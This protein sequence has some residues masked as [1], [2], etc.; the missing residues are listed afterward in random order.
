MRSTET[1]KGSVSVFLALILCVFLTLIFA[2]LESARFH[3]AKAVLE[4]A[5]EGAM[6]SV[7]SGYQRELYERYGL[8]FLDGGFGTGLSNPEMLEQEYSLWFEKNCG[9]SFVS[10]QLQTVRLQRTVTAADYSGEVFRDSALRIERL[11]WEADSE[12]NA[13]FSALSSQTER[14]LTVLQAGEAAASVQADPGFSLSSDAS[15]TEAY[16]ILSA[17][18]TISNRPLLQQALPAGT[19]LSGSILSEEGLPSREMRDAR[20]LPEEAH[21]SGTEGL[22]EGEEK[23]LYLS[24]LLD[25]FPCF[26]GE[27]DTFG[28][29]CEAEYLAFGG[30]SDT[31]NLNTLLLRLYPALL[32]RNLRAARNTPGILSEIAELSADC[33]E[34]TGQSEA[35]SE[36][37]LW[38]YT[39]AETLLE[40]RTLLQGGRIPYEKTEGSWV[41]RK[42][43]IRNLSYGLFPAREHAEEMFSAVP[44]FSCEEVLRAILSQVLQEELS[45][46]AMD[47]IQENL[48]GQNSAF[49]MCSL[50]FGMDF[51]VRAAGELLFAKQPVLQNTRESA[52]RMTLPAKTIRG[53]YR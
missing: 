23:H 34:E 42:A 36:K 27:Q 47:L 21:F 37:L 1:G 53:S 12:G 35:V 22:T 20:T 50:I 38:S 6:D 7:L 26:S 9:G 43:E 29:G 2:L 13:S 45:Y 40:L 14:I 30:R 18:R 15:D 4:R 41:M 44:G 19:V 5:A 11:L 24:Y 31:D 48:R 52:V 33:E 39:K 17:V 46:R 25:F 28:L 16:R 32:G 3:A 8:L 49:L 10:L 51:E